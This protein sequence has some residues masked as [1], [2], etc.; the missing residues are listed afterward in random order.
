M[1]RREA[2]SLRSLTF[3]E[4]MLMLV[5]GSLAL[6]FPVRAS[7]WITGVVAV[8]FLVAGL[9]SWIVTLSRARQLSGLHTFWRLVVATLL[10]LSGLWM[11][12]SM[13]AGPA[14][15]AR[16]VVRFALAIGWVFLVEGLVA[17]GVALS[18]RHVPGWGWGLLN[19]LIS[20]GLGGVILTIK[21]PHLGAILGSLVGI[22]FVCSGL[23]LLI[24][25]TR[26]HGDEQGPRWG[27]PGSFN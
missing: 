20:L 22:S 7:V 19:G 10:G 8:G 23:D 15:E 5:L 25:G 24:F 11:V 9:V 3:A 17:T 6:A 13:A 21:S 12:V 27:K 4:G 14:A 18:H 16:Q 26:F 2:R 1:R